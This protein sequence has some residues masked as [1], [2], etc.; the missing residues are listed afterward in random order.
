MSHAIDPI[1]LLVGLLPLTACGGEAF[2]APQSGQG[3]AASEDTAADVAGTY[4]F[5]VTNG[6]NDCEFADWEAG[7]QTSGLEV[8]L[9]Q[10][11]SNVTAVVAGLVGTYFVWI[12]GTNALTGTVVGSDLALEATGTVVHAFEACEMRMSAEL[13]G[14]ANGDAIQ[15]TL[16]Y[17]PVT[18]GHADCGA[19]NECTNEQKFSGSRPPKGT[20]E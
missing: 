12:T 11:E 1:W 3:G 17:K 13:E 9:T 14:T 7:A 4:L 19:L 6:P 20:A 15:G 8:T 5:S 16:R 2:E 18:N 10:N